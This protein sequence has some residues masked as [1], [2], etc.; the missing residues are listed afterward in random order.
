M[1]NKNSISTR[2]SL[3]PAVGI[4]WLYQH[5][6][7]FSHSVPLADGQHYGEAVTGVKDHADY[8]EELRNAGKLAVLPQA[9]QE[10]Y[11]SIPRGRVV[12]HSDSDMFFVYHDNNVSKSDLNKVCKT[13][14]LPKAKT[15]FEQD[16]HYCDVNDEDWNM[17]YGK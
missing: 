12:Y 10:E 4:F 1:P 16:I 5:K 13:F 15:K 3:V 6:I 8:W 7:I 14:N 2:D 17:I 9:L 11:F